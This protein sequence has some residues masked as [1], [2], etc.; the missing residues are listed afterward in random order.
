MAMDAANR[1]KWK[2]AG[3]AQE[4]ASHQSLI[5]QTSVETERL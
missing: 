1:V 3:S 5:V 2:V 4:E